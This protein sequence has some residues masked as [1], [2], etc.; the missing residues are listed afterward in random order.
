[1]RFK[2]VFI[3]GAIA[4]LVIVAAGCGGG[5]NSTSSKSTTTAS[6]SG[7]STTTKS[8]A[9]K[10]KNESKGASK[11]LTKSQFKTRINEICI[12]VPPGYE[13]ELKE[14]EK[15]VKK[16]TK[17]EINLK[18]ALPPLRS[19]VEQMETVE[20]PAGEEQTLQTVI[21]ALVSAADGLEEKPTSE[22]SGPKSP[23]AEFQKV[24]KELGFETCSGL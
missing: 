5:S 18:A 11:P 3:L 16:P 21:D 10:S 12:Q 15:S 17:S 1:M 19:A 23:F 24:T 7:K 20:P 9:G 22:L 4:A 6:G 8:Q 14:L 2:F 13:N